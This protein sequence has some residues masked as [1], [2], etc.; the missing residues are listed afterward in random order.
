MACA[1]TQVG[2]I[3]SRLSLEELLD[4]RRNHLGDGGAARKAGALYAD[5]VA[6]PRQA[7]VLLVPDDEVACR[8]T[9]ALERGPYAAHVGVQVVQAH[10]REVPDHVPPEG[11][12]VGL[13]LVAQLLHVVGVGPELGAAREVRDAVDAEAGLVLGLG[14][15]DEHGGWGLSAEAEVVAL[16]PVYPVPRLV[17]VDAGHLC[18]LVGREAG[19]VDADPRLDPVGV[20]ARRHLNYI[21]AGGLRDAGD[22]GVQDQGVLAGLPPGLPVEVVHKAVGVDDACGGAE[23]GGVGPDVGL[24]PVDLVD[25]QHLQVPCSA[26]GRLLHG[27]PDLPDLVLAV[28]HYELPQPLVGHPVLLAYL[29]EHGVS[30]DAEPGLAAC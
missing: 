2:A 1:S 22:L 20:A 11:L 13:H 3:A 29:V 18:Y 7:P 9:G 6:E 26:G 28:G 21:A 24:Q 12:P 19:A 5:E 25:V 23:E 30:L 4:Y 15:V 8:L 14:G 10:R 16:A 27:L 17:G